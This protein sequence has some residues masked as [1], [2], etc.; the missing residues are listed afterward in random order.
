MK[1]N[2]LSPVGNIAQ[3]SLSTLVILVV[4][5]WVAAGLHT[6]SGGNPVSGI[7][8][9]AFAE[10]LARFLAL[11]V[12]ASQLPLNRRTVIIT[13]GA[14]F[15]LLEI[16][17]AFFPENYASLEAQTSPFWL[18][19]GFEFIFGFLFHSALTWIA[20]LVRD[21]SSSALAFILTWTIHT[22]W[23]ALLMS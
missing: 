21:R 15:G 2:F 10:E 8:A 22:A 14:S 20:A 3:L 9:F 12:V 16:S 23:N 7:V 19:A 1:N 11:F 18:L 17:N 13:I 6:V 5:S 4:I